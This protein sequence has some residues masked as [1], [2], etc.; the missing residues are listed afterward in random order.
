[1]SV[2]EALLC[3]TPVIYTRTAP[4]EL[5]ETERC[6]WWCD[7][8]VDTLATKIREAMALDADTLRGMGQRGHD[9]TFALCSQEV[10]A[11]KM[12]RLYDWLVNGGEKP[13]FVGE[14]GN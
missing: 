9:A 2:A 10:V 6:G 4:W 7:N 12:M 1:M 3:H 8:D 5:L 11:R 14:I 13:E